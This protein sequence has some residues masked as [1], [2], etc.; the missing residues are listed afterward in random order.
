MPKLIDPKTLDRY[1]KA[2]QG[3]QPAGATSPI[4]LKRLRERRPDLHARVLSGEMSLHAASVA[5]GLRSPSAR[6]PL[7]SVSKAVAV[8]HEHFREQWPEVVAKVQALT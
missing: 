6:L 8:L 4:L 2:S 5:G 3:R 1:E 7:N